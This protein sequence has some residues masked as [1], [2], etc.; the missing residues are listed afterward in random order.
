MPKKIHNLPT[1]EIFGIQRGG[2]E[3]NC[4]KNVFS[5]CRMSKW[6]GGGNVYFFLERD[7]SFLAKKLNGDISKSNQ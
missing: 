3:K 1:E 6:G 7:G 2:G 5:L 4:L